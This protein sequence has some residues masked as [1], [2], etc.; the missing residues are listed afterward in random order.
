[1]LMKINGNRGMVEIVMVFVKTLGHNLT[2]S[3]FVYI[4]TSIKIP[5]SFD[6]IC[7]IQQY[8]PYF[9]MKYTRHI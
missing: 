6:D 5:F 4:H 8:L 1:M 9:K 2:V 7:I 3:E